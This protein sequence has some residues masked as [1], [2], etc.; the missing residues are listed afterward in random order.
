MDTQDTDTPNDAWIALIAI[1]YCILVENALD[2]AFGRGQVKQIF[3]S[4]FT[5]ESLIQHVREWDI[6][7]RH[8][9]DANAA[10]AAERITVDESEVFSAPEV[11]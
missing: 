7:M 3:R 6:A 2:T 1:G 8:I 5:A 11:R 9:E 4:A 10:E